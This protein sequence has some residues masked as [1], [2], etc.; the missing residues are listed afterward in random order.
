[1]IVTLE[2]FSYSDM[3]VFGKITLPSGQ[4][5][6]TV[7][8]PWLD[9]KK[10][11][12]CIPEGVYKCAPRD[13]HRGGYKAIEILDVPRRKFILFH[14]GNTI[15]DTRGCICV[16]ARVGALGHLWA[17][18]RSNAAFSVLMRELGG[19]EFTLKITSKML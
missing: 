1:M 16:G 7:E 9:N 19:K 10:S 11:I 12:S 3:G 17:V 4:E 6:S 5:L 2:R 14:K 18:L 8:P 13:Y 15:H